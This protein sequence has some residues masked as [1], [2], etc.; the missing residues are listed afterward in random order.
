[1]KPNFL[2]HGSRLDK[3]RVISTYQKPPSSEKTS[4]FNPALG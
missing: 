4:P 2:C 1:M 3:D